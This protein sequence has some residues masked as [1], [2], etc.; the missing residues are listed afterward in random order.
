MGMTTT[1]SNSWQQ[2]GTK[3]LGYIGIAF[4]ALTALDAATQNYIIQWLGPNWG[5]F[6]KSL[7]LVA[8]AVAVALR[9]HKNTT[10][11]ATEIVN[12]SSIGSVSASAQVVTEVAKTAVAAEDKAAD[13]P[14]KPKG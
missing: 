11:I 12:Q 10:D 5:P 14:A 4:G 3:I 8:G 13:A 1:V 2:N 6:A 9:G 7:F